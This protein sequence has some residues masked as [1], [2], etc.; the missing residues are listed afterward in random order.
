MAHLMRQNMREEA[1]KLRNGSAEGAST[2]LRNRRQ[3]GGE[4]RFLHVLQHHPLAALFMHHA[5]VVREIVG[6]G[7]HAVIAVAG[8]DHLIHHANR[9]EPSDLRIA[10]L[11]VDR[12]VVLD[13]LHVIAEELQLRRLHVVADIDIG[14]V[15]RLVSEQFVV[16]GFVR[17]DRDVDR[18][19]EIHP[20]YVA[21][22]VIV[23]EE[24]GRARFEEVFQRRV[25]GQL[26]GIAQQ[27]RALLRSAA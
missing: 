19:V 18:R 8:R 3:R 12:Q 10:I 14:F 7:F 16:V 23:G 5:L 13:F 17:P 22:V 6:R 27:P 1:S 15:S 20:R 21:F 2:D 4:F 24:R 9:R 26:R 11:R 25:I